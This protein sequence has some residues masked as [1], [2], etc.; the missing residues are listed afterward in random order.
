VGYQVGA[1]CEYAIGIDAKRLQVLKIDLS[2][3]LFLALVIV[4]RRLV[5]VSPIAACSGGICQSPDGFIQRYF[6]LIELTSQRPG[7]PPCGPGLRLHQLGESGQRPR[8]LA[9]LRLRDRSHWRWARADPGLQPFHQSLYRS[10]HLVWR[11][12]PAGSLQIGQI[13]IGQ[14]AASA[15]RPLN[16]CSE[17]FA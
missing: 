12:L 7:R 2:G 13:Q 15:G 10:I 11:V 8:E 9:N 4:E 3:R 17:V 14:I 6:P 16:G 1:A 5:F